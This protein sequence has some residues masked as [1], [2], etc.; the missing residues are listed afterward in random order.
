MFDA[1]RKHPG[2]KVAAKN[3]EGRS[4]GLI[5]LCGRAGMFG[6]L[7]RCRGIRPA[8]AK[9]SNQLRERSGHHSRAYRIFTISSH[10]QPRCSRIHGSSAWYSTGGLALGP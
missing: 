10:Q 9:N 4:A 8:P 6:C 2:G 7:V 5:R 1:L 3:T